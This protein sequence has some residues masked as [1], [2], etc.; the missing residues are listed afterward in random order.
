MVFLIPSQSGVTMKSIVDKVLKETQQKTPEEEAAEMLSPEDEELR[1][2]VESMKVN[3]KIVGCGGGG[4]NTINRLFHEGIT[5]AELIALNTDAKHLLTI[6]AQ[7][8]IL[9]GKKLT[10]GLGAG[11]I[12]EV[13]E[14]A[15]QENE[16]EIREI[17]KGAH[18]VF[19]TAGMG[20]GTGTGSAYYVA[21]M[22]KE[23][24]ALVMAVVT[25][26]FKAEGI[27]RMEN[28]KKGLEKLRRVC[29]T[30]IVIP[31]D[32]LLEIVPR[33]PLDAA[34]KVA[35]EI[36]M[37]SIKGLTEI[38]TKPGLV[39]LD[40]NDV[41][42]IME[43]AGMAII[44][45]GESDAPSNRVEE[46][47]NEALTSPLLGDVDISEGRG[48]LIRVVGGPDMTVSEAEKAAK[49]VSEKISKNAKIIWGCSVEPD[50][51]RTIRVLLVVTGVKSAHIMGS[52]SGFSGPTSSDNEIEFVR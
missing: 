20:G 3:I 24:G 8:K 6:K 9:I 33:M 42:T 18:I 12:P 50:L 43:G 34:F 21:K 27:Q 41:R 49:M 37:Q 51:E 38:I 40:Y 26:P 7:K 10:R 17:L 47:M 16:D 45:I 29:D 30:T 11:A 36:L 32:R 46:A 48:A 5:G 1:K 35:D 23:E 28:A 2:L 4:S 14:K 25:L 44:G 13:G 39:N 22:A 52:D 15:A 31:N 19:V